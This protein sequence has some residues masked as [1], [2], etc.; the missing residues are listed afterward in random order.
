VAGDV[1][2]ETVALDELADRLDEG[3]PSGPPTEDYLRGFHR[4]EDK[5]GWCGMSVPVQPNT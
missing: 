2:V 5:I 3:Q 4:P 1:R